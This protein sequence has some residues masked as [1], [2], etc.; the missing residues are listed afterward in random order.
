MTQLGFWT[1]LCRSC[2]L[3]KF[4]DCEY[5]RRSRHANIK[6]LSFP[7]QRIKQA[8]SR[9]AMPK[10]VQDDQTLS[11]LQPRRNRSASPGTAASERQ[12]LALHSFSKAATDPGNGTR[13]SDELVLLQVS[14]HIWMYYNCSTLVDPLY[15]LLE[16]GV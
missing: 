3:P 4:D 9:R 8:S 14:L 5:S 1:T 15:Q 2:I 13:L 10:H 7:L 6:L 11:L 12:Q 16:A